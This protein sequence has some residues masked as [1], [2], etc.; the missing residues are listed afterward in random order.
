VTLNRFNPTD[1]KKTIGRHNRHNRCNPHPRINHPTRH[2]RT[3]I[4]SMVSMIPSI[5]D[6]LIAT[7]VR[8]SGT[9]NRAKESRFRHTVTD[10][11]AYLQ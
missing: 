10:R 6:E 8:L 11:S 1:R 4:E 3:T 5:I 9:N 2:N 7:V